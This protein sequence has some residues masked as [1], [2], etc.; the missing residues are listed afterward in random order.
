MARAAAASVTD[1][2]SGMRL[3][4]LSMPASVAEP[5]P[6][7][8]CDKSQAI[9]KKDSLICYFGL[10][11]SKVDAILNLQ[12][13]NEKRKEKKMNCEICKKAPA[14]VGKYESEFGWDEAT[15]TQKDTKV[16]LKICKGCA[17]G[18]YDGTE[19]YPGTHKI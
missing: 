7:G 12:E 8:K 9:L 11:I 13:K 6:L 19:E 10:S 5:L 3:S 15:G 18:A 16:E 4:V 14:E 17:E 2:N 1:I